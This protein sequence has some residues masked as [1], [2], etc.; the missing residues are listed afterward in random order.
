MGTHKPRGGIKAPQLPG[1]L[2]PAEMPDDMPVD[3]ETYSR[4]EYHGLNLAERS[5]SRP[6]FETVIF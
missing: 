6:H 4:L 2:P 5:I 1:A 3:S